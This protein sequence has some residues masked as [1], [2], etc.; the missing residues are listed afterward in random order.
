MDNLGDAADLHRGVI[1]QPRQPGE[2]PAL[3]VGFP[4]LLE[5][6]RQ[7]ETPITHFVEGWSAEQ[8]PHEIEKVLNQGH[9]VG[10]HGWQ[11]EKWN[12]LEEEQLTELAIR[13]TDAITTA[14]GIRPTSFRAP[15]GATTLHSAKTIID[16][17][18][19]IDASIA[20]S[21]QDGG[22]VANIMGPL[23]KTPYTW[24]GVDASHWLWQKHTSDE[25]EKI[26]K[27]ELDQ[28]ASQHSHFIFIWHPHV[29]GIDPER[30]KTGR[31]ILEYVKNN[32]ESFRIASL[33]ELVEHYQE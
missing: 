31:N 1:Q 4:A 9:Q 15:G 28:R 22:P 24:P 11:H 5:L 21:G 33:K 13:A 32:E 30:I 19:T 3:E 17:G 18:Y 27:T 14:G 23:W 16:L 26:W 6:Y 20:P 8:Y 10:M 12:T 7:F 29:M 25:V 2:R